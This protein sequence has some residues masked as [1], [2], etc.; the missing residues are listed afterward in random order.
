MNSK[1]TK[2]CVIGAGP[3]GLTAAKN[4]LQ[5]GI[6]VKV[7][8]KNNKVG[9]NWVFNAKT[10]HSSV[11]NNTHIISSKVWSEYEDFP[12][13]ADYPDYPKHDQVQQYFESYATHFGVMENISFETTVTKVEKI[14]EYEWHVDYQNEQGEKSSEVFTHLMLANGHHWKPNHPEYDGE[15][16]GQYMHSHDFKGVDDSWKDKKVLVI[17]AGNS[18]C[19]VAVESARVA[20]TVSMS[21][22]S[23][24][25]F[26]PKFMFGK[27]A[28][29]LGT[30]TNRLPKK[31]R[32]L[33][34]T[35]L[36][37]LM[38]GSY[39]N[40]H[41]PVPK[42]LVLNQH[43]TLNSDLLDYIR[44]DRIKPRPAIQSFNGKEVS[45]SD[46]RVE[47]Y[48]TVVA[49]TGFKMAFPFLDKAFIDFEDKNRVPLYKKMLHTE[50]KSLYF[51][52]LFQPLGCIWPLADYQAKLAC[53]E[54]IG[55]YQRPIN[56]SAAVTK[57]ILN[58]HF[59][60]QNSARHSTEVD[61]HKFRREL[62]AEL[63]SVGVDIGQA[64]A[65]REKHY[66]DFSSNTIKL[67]TN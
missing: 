21:M 65:G 40:Y 46:G 62:K 26:I 10:G 12:M 44:H 54:I 47:T 20:D 55:N 39:K 67:Q 57:E 63:K 31:L 14:S 29:E 30:L 50:H 4:C 45:F 22:R 66:K 32:Q 16:T 59:D 51:V 18:A 25:W 9:G 28:D 34:F 3:S 64:P 33:L 56:M 52:G 13:P 43:P 36:L 61:Y 5:Y 15:Y 23:P 38:Q 8:E 6:D 27:P 19:D 2:V 7:F 48:D 17:G 49:C 60:F 53:E 24:Q 11:Y 58:P 1:A 42:E 35:G 41:L 37:K